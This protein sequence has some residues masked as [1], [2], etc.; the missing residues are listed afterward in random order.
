MRRPAVPKRKD[1]AYE[2]RPSPGRRGV[3]VALLHLLVGIDAPQP[4]LLD[5]TVKTVAGDAAP[6]GCALLDLGHH[7]GLQAGCDRAAGIW[8]VVERGQVILGLHGDYGG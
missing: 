6:A 7:A 4:L 2:S 8:A 1:T 3:F 5:P